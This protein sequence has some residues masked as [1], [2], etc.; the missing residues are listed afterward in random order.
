MLKNK[1]KICSGCGKE[2]YIFSKGKCK[3]CQ[4]KKPLKSKKKAI[5]KIS[6]K[7][8][9][10]KKEK[11]ERTKEIH[12]AMYNWW[13]K[14]PKNEC[15]ACGCKLPNDFHTW[16]VDHL[17]EKSTY[18]EFALDERN[19][20]LI[21]FEDH[22]AKTNGFARPKHIEAIRKAKIELL[23]IGMIEKLKENGI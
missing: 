2:A 5:N 17:I 16:M 18:P 11:S 13:L 23:T 14:Q 9:I 22:S 4:P 19:F 1:K 10:K 20:F 15:M 6:E 12:Q 3:F 7:G 8:L 21:C